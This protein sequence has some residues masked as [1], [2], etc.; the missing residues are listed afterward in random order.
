M[1]TAQRLESGH[2]IGQG[3]GWRF[4]CELSFGLEAVRPVSCGRAG[5][6]ARGR[7]ASAPPHPRKSD[8][9][10]AARKFPVKHIDGGRLCWLSTDYHSIR[11]DQWEHRDQW[12]D[13]RDQRASQTHWPRWWQ[14]RATWPSNSDQRICLSVVG[15]AFENRFDFDVNIIDVQL[16]YIVHFTLTT[17]L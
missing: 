8:Q 2:E 16:L 6:R 13:Q 10:K 4:R 3:I 14:Q 9:T 1:F 17:C 7:G 11:K 15:K 12:R 5:E